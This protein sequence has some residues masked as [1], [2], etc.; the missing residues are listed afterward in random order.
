M[1]KLRYPL[2]RKHFLA[3][4]LGSLLVWSTGQNIVRIGQR[5]Y[6][7]LAAIPEPLPARQK[8]LETL[9]QLSEL[10]RTEKQETLLFIPLQNQ[11]YWQWSQRCDSTPFIAPAITGMALVDGL[12]I[13][14]CG[15]K[16]YYGYASYEWRS[17]AERLTLATDPSQLCEAVRAQGFARVIIIKTDSKDD[18]IL[19]R[20]SCS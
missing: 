5:Y 11:L 12:P 19:E 9:Y 20:R 16:N 8:L 14:E 7:Q 6:R 13:P 2:S 3:I 4:L 10:P 1:H 17:P 15:E 18:V